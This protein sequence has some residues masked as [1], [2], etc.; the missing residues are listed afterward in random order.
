[1]SVTRRAAAASLR[2]S[3]ENLSPSVVLNDDVDVEPPIR[4]FILDP[5]ARC[6]RITFEFASPSLV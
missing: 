2:Y 5:L 3:M 1:M 4:A 6:V